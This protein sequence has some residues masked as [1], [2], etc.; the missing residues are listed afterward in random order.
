[1]KTQEDLL[2]EAKQLANLGQEYGSI[3]GQL[4]PE[5]RLRLKAY[6]L[7]MDENIAVK[8]IYGAVTWKERVNVTKGRGRPKK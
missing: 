3:V 5:N 4:E 7:N 2:F 6:V 8:T 1:M